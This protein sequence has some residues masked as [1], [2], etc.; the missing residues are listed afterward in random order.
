[1]RTFSRVAISI[2]LLS[3]SR[4]VCAPTNHGGDDDVVPTPP[5]D[6]RPPPPIDATDIDA[7]DT[8]AIPPDC[9]A[10]AERGL[11]WLVTHQ[12]VDGSYDETIATTAFAV[13]KLETYAREL[14]L[15]P[16][17]AGFLYHN[18]V[19][20]G[21]DYLFL[22]ARRVPLAM[23]V[24]GNP[25]GNGNGTG[26]SFAG[27]FDE[28]YEHAIA[29]MAIAG[30]AE[31]D[32]V[33]TTAGSALAGLTFRAV[34]EDAVD[35][36]VMAQSDSSQSSPTSCTRGGWRY[37]P[38]D[39]NGSVGDNSVTQWAT[40]AL[41]YAHHPLY[42]FEV[43]IQD[44]VMTE[45]RDW[46]TCIQNRAGGHDDG[47]AGYTSPNEWVNAYKT[48]ALIQQ[49]SFV[50]DL[51]DAPR[52]MAARAYLQRV[53]ADP[54]NGWRAVPVSDYLAM[55]SIMKG[56]ESMAITTLGPIDWYR[57]FCDRLKAE[58]LADGSWRASRWDRDPLGMQS[59]VWA[60]LVLER[61]A[62]PPEIIP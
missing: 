3:T 35:Y 29:V 36:L 46:V 52:V 48:G 16:F 23:Q 9:F 49:A 54:T 34:V 18:Q 42:H 51:A 31:P 55:Y 12:Q 24:H 45:V 28:T 56:M 17:D 50:G 11:A 60:L 14:G 22:Q 15:S 37:Q 27:G 53:W 40:L 1:M 62:P 44:W 32:R 43:P 21:L 20:A 26:L 33:V 6:A 57:E 58:Q 4:C 47:G 5:I 25:D 8:A 61:A 7:P 59:T 30:G 41:E 19:S 38:F 2:A 10:A 13:L 39:N